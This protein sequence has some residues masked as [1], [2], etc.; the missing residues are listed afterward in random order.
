MFVFTL[1]ERNF[2]VVVVNFIWSML[3]NEIK[4]SRE[5]RLLLQACAVVFCWLQ[6]SPWWC[7]SLLPVVRTCW[8]CTP[9]NTRRRIVYY[10]CLL[11]I[12][13]LRCVFVLNVIRSKKVSGSMVKSLHVLSV[14]QS[15]DT[16]TGIVFLS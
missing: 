2:V 8:L 3:N 13:Q 10:C 11:F 6:C 1:C 4:I 15:K 7:A 5:R 14:S 12:T 16:Q 9:S